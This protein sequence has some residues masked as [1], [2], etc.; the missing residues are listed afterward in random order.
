ML[1]I[2][3]ILPLEARENIDYDIFRENLS[4]ELEAENLG[5]CIHLESGYLGYEKNYFAF[6]VELTAYDDGFNRLRECCLKMNPTPKIIV[7]LVGADDNP[8]Q[9]FP[10]NDLANVLEG[11]EAGTKFLSDWEKL[12]HESFNEARKRRESRKQ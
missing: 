3:V 7:S 8:L 5:R 1:E 11:F 9:I 6:L 2:V 4:K 12:I 10:R